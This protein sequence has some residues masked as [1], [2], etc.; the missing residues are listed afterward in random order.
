MNSKLTPH[1]C[2]AHPNKG[3]GL[4]SKS[5]AVAALFTALP[6]F[7]VTCTELQ[8]Q[9]ENK[10]RTTGLSQFTVSIADVNAPTAGKVVGSCEGGAKKLIYTLASSPIDTSF[11]P[12]VPPKSKVEQILTECRDGSVSMGGDCKK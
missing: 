9:I 2:S 3:L 1:P 12:P 10:I 4:L 7:A 8:M 11:A 5:I 6:S